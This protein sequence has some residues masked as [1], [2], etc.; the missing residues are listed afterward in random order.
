MTDNLKQNCIDFVREFGNTKTT[1]DFNDSV[2][3]LHE[4]AKK[5][6]NQAI[7]DAAGSAEFILTNGTPCKM[8]KQEKQ[9]I[10]KL[11]KK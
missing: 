6:C 7:K 2:D 1:E 10:L 4:F 11:L 8:S 5:I 3:N 9:S